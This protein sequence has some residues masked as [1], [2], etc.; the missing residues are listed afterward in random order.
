MEVGILWRSDDGGWLTG[1]TVKCHLGKVCKVGANRKEELQRNHWLY[2]DLWYLV[3]M[4]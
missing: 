1:A 3:E 2:D 4:Q